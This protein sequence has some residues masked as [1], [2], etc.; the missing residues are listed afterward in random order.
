[1]W[2]ADKIGETVPFFSDER[3]YYMSRQPEGYINIVHKDDADII[4]C[5][6]EEIG[7]QDDW[8]HDDNQYPNVNE[9]INQEKQD[10][11]LLKDLDRAGFLKRQA[12]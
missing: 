5:N 2:Y 9:A 7:S 4:E 11:E 8:W 12:D 10:E 1:M 3:A 6:D